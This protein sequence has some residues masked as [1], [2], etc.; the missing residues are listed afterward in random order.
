MMRA[1]VEARR[2][3]LPDAE[4]ARVGARPEICAHRRLALAERAAARRGAAWSPCTRSSRRPRSGGCCPSSRR[5]ARSSILVVPVERMVRDDRR[6]DQGRGRSRRSGGG[7]SSSTA[8]S[9]RAPSR[10]GDAPARGAPRARR[11]RR[12]AGTRRSGPPT[13]SLEVEPGVVLERRWVPLDTVGV[14]VPRNLVSTLVMCAVPAQVAGVRAHRR[15]HA[16][17]RRR[18]RSPPRPRLLGIDEVWALGGPQAIGWLAYVRARRQDRRPGNA[19]VNEAKLEVWR[20]VRSTCPAGRPRSSSLGDGDPRLV[21]LELAAQAR[22]RPRGR[23]P[24][25]RDARG[26]RGDRA[27][28][29]R[30]ARRRRGARRHGAQRRRGLRRPVVAGRGRRLRDRRQPRPADERLGALGR[31]ARPRDVPQAGHDPAAHAEGLA[32]IRP[33]VEA[34]AAAEGMPAHAEAVRR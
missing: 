25:R 9:R 8:S 4:R 5:R 32:R 33:T 18:A 1:V 17:R 26:G 12:A 7:R 30:A 10:A 6:G 27:R 29:P 22:A 2:A 20:D 13:S 19:Y 23:L 14:Y 11:P 24:R 3:P 31:R 15:L 16:A 28:A 34:L 21:E